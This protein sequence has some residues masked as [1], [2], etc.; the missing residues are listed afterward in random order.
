MLE[1]WQDRL[2]AEYKEVSDRLAKLNRFLQNDENV[3]A[4]SKLDAGLLIA[5]SY[6]MA[7]YLDILKTRL[8]RAECR[9]E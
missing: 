7:Q 4:L 9:V 2:Q 8:L 1:T 5:Q 3:G 6:A